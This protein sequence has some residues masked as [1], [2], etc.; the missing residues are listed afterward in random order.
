MTIK[1]VEEIIKWWETKRIYY[2]IFVIIAYTLISGVEGS[3]N[4]IIN[5]KPVIYSKLFLG[6]TYLCVTNLM[7]LLGSG[8]ELTLR[9]Y[10]IHIGSLGCYIILALG[11]ILTFIDICIHDYNDHFLKGLEM[12]TYPSMGPSPN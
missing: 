3:M 2:I 9:K 8:V 6:I 4:L 1:S 7:Y 12:I 5:G 11:F 10:K